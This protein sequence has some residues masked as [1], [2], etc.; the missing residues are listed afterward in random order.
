MGKKYYVVWQGVKPGIYDSWPQCQ[1]QVKGHPDAKFKSYESFEQAQKAFAQPFAKALKSPTKGAGK[2]A[3]KGKSVTAP[4]HSKFDVNI[5]CDG[6][7][8][9]NPGKSGTGVAV[10]HKEKLA[11]LWYGL[12]D[13]NGTNNTA[14]LNGLLMAFKAAMHYI[15]QGRK[16]QILSDS[17]YSIDCITK[18]AKGWQAKGWKRASG[19]EIKNLALIQTCYKF[20]EAIKADIAV[21][22]VKGHAD[23][24][25]NELADRMAVYARNQKEPQFVAYQE[26]LDIDKILAMESG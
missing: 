13:A 10:Y 16:V 25:G 15:K 6:A 12:Y 7:C 5:Y 21:T 2:S 9:P 24:E 3:A 4:D 11:G 1:A 17:K 20:Y 8:S 14:E 19:E 23:V 26:T 18:W 22:H